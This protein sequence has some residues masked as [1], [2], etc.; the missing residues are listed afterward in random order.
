M[1]PLKNMLNGIL[2]IAFEYRQKE[3]K[4]N[5]GRVFCAINL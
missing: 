2:S 5:S 4:S 1:Y 3:G